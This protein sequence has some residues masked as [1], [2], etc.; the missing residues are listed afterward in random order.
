MKKHV[1]KKLLAI[2]L[3]FAMLTPIIGNLGTNA[4]KV[5]AAE[6][7]ETIG[8]KIVAANDVSEETID[9][10]KV[11]KSATYVDYI[12]AGWYTDEAATIAAA[13]GSTGAY[14]RFVPD[15]VLSTKVQVTNGIVQNSAIE[16][17]NG[18]YVMRFVSSVDSI[19]YKYA[20]FELS[21]TD[22]D[23]NE[24][25]TKTSKTYKAF[26]RIDST[27]GVTAN[28]V[29]TYNFSPKVVDTKSEY[30]ITGKLPVAEA[31][32]A[33][34]YTVKAYWMTKDGTKVFGKAR[35][36]SVE[37]GIETTGL[38]VT[39]DGNLSG[40]GYTAFYTR[41][42]GNQ[43]TIADTS[44]EILTTGNGYSNVRLKGA[45]RDT[46]SVTTISISDGT[47]TYTTTY[48]NLY[49]K[50]EDENGHTRADGSWYSAN[51]DEYIIATRADMYGFANLVD[52]SHTDGDTTVQTNSFAG[53][54]VY[55]VSDIALN[56]EKLELLEGNH[57][58]KWYTYDEEHQKVYQDAP[59]HNWN[60]IGTSSYVFHGVFDGQGHTVSGLYMDTTARH[61]G[62]FAA[63]SDSATIKNIKLKGTHI[64]TTAADAGSVAASAKGTFSSIYS[65][66]IVE[67]VE[68]SGG[69]VGQAAG[70]DLQMKN[71]WFA[72]KITNTT[73]DKQ[74]I[75]GIAGVVINDAKV[76][77][78]SCLNTGTVDVSAY[79]TKGTYNDNYKNQAVRPWAGGLIGQV[80]MG[81]SGVAT[82][83]DSLNVGSIVKN[84]SSTFGYGAII[85]CSLANSQVTLTNAYG[86]QA[87][88]NRNVTLLGTYT[89]TPI[90]VETSIVGDDAK[91]YMPK[92]EWDNTWT[93][94]AYGI[95]VLSEFQEEVID[96]DWYNEDKNI[97]VLE[98]KGD[99]YGL[100]SL[101]DTTDFTG[102]TVKLGQDIIVNTG[103]AE[104]WTEGVVPY[105][106]WTPIGGNGVTT[107]GFAGT[108]DGQGH[109]ISG[110]YLKTN[111]RYTGLF[112]YL[113]GGTLS[114][115][116]LTNSYLETSGR[117]FGSIVGLCNG[118]LDSVYS[119]AIA[120]SSNGVA[121]GLAGMINNSGKTM[122][123][124]NCWFA[125]T[126]K[127]TGT[128]SNNTAGLVGNLYA[129]TLNMTDCLNTGTVDVSAFTD[130]RPYVGGLISVVSSGTT[131]NIT[132]CLNVGMVKQSAST[133]DGYGPIVGW[134]A[135]TVTLTNV[136]ATGESC[137]HFGKSN[138]STLANSIGNVYEYTILG[139]AAATSSA[140]SALIEN[141]EWVTTTYG[142]PVLKEFQNESD[143][144]IDISWFNEVQYDS[145]D[146]YILYD[147]KDLYGFTMI[148]RKKT[149][150]GKTIKLGAD[151]V[152]NEG[153]ASATWVSKSNY[154]QWLPIGS[155]GQL[156]KI[157]FAGKFD[158]QGHT[159]SGLYHNS[160]NRY[161]GLFAGVGATG[162]I[163]N[164][165][166]I[167]SYFK[168]GYK[169]NVST[170]G[171]DFGSIAGFGAGK[172]YNICSDVIMEGQRPAIGGII[173][174]ANGTDVVLEN[175][176]FK[177][178]V[179]NTGTGST[180]V[181]GTGGLVGVAY[182]GQLTLLNCLNSGEVNVK[183]YDFNQGTTEEPVIGPRAGG[184]IGELNDDIQVEI[185]NCLNIGEIV[186]NEAATVAYGP[187]IGMDLNP[188]S[189]TVY[190]TY[191]TEESCA[192]TD[193]SSMEAEFT[194][195]AETDITTDAQ[196][197]LPNLGIGDGV[198]VCES[199]AL[200]TLNMVVSDY[201][202]KDTIATAEEAA[203]LTNLYANRTLY[204]G[205]LHD[206]AKTYGNRTDNDLTYGDDGNT[207]LQTWIDTDIAAA[208]LDFVAS[209]DHQQVKHWD[210][211]LWQENKNKLI[212]GTEA[213]IGI[214][215][216]QGTGE[217]KMHFSLLLPDK[218]K[219]TGVLNY[220][221]LFQVDT[222]GFYSKN[223]YPDATKETFA[224]FLGN[225]K[226]QGGF[227]VIAHP[228]QTG[229]SDNVLD[230]YFCDGVGFE[231]I[232]NSL[233]SQNTKD[234]Y[235]V[236]KTL[237]A[238]GK[239]I[240]ACAGSDAHGKEVLHN[241]TLTSV[242]ADSS[243]ETDK[244]NIIPYLSAGNFTAGSVGIQMCMGSDT[245]M[246]GSCD[247]TGMKLVVGIDE[248]HS[249]VK[250]AEHKYRVDIL[251]EDGVVYSKKITSD[252][253]VQL[254][255]DA[256]DCDFY[257]VEVVN[258]TT[259][260]RIAIGNPIWNER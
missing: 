42:D 126:I 18:K 70:T 71:C 194:Q 108:F 4:G 215:D 2:V 124:S 211:D 159:I 23:T 200:P 32:K 88:S 29:D 256:K 250:N 175:C 184:L 6:E 219:L 93:T 178:T 104:D 40:S 13:S 26:K 243:A 223:A 60:P 149:F 1:L 198:W 89:G 173:G 199:G 192:A 163:Q 214:V 166:L 257:R 154:R 208:E 218:E 131:A 230:S 188:T 49:S 226:T 61:A 237:L 203:L 17:Y 189:T 217:Q 168:T 206:H 53:K 245:S 123:M 16:K 66:A 133:T 5:Q 202:E 207:P 129:G 251:N 138:L 112:G 210:L 182:Q 231:V 191:S 258:E 147:E 20:G 34:N 180:G 136:S 25:V 78:T 247:F 109:T 170:S 27:T 119:N 252:G 195:I 55:L 249:S 52:A 232:Y 259:G 165:N 234:N 56:P 220:N 134:K 186:V 117:D 100:A 73:T 139:D 64:T 141:D 148:S 145:T 83:E 48:R 254:A 197:A 193:L 30:F 57:Y 144:R 22:K 11:Y 79:N 3:V 9:G 33:V 97:Y 233:E 121:G 74:G 77:M 172:F 46:K 228:M 63:T 152:V 127:N 21:Y 205:E 209:L 12:F 239:R 227:A 169:S 81:T 99:L 107:K 132:R 140:T 201:T 67:C 236:W 41:W 37:D 246:G 50:Y 54:K 161:A 116:K 105:Y 221:N 47:N 14:A 95:P 153:T 135:G 212:Y 113:N 244:G 150:S 157:D 59:S 106:E 120:V 65:D 241:R 44:V 225:V 31:D 84:A 179:T 229:Y 110:V 62:L 137:T 156:T 24:V 167:N 142:T 35:C 151:I 176:W 39:V 190:A 92:L 36:V 146:E 94:V 90:Q 19:D 85:G 181:R 8:Y 115:F 240:F 72:G 174:Q 222:D 76:T 235:A 91:T 183:A 177:G 7:E 118:N 224:T 68:R 38:N 216:K 102:K 69:I 86:T 196:S 213:A 204:Q 43:V 114:D 143:G 103:S 255:I 238:N 58:L 242:Y 82:I 155:T 10:I 158:G 28:D 160:N 162:I 122:T 111:A 98:D 253:N 171:R 45:T 164:V 185:G 75:G 80:G 125:G 260:V 187:I 128:N 248:F 130:T 96:T 87:S 101:I 15:D 51:E